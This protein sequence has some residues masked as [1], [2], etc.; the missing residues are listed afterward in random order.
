MIEYLDKAIR[1]VAGQ[2]INVTARLTTD[3]GDLIKE[4][5]GLMFHG[6]ND[7]IKMYGGVYFS[8]TELWQFT[9]PAEDTKGLR[10]RYWY[11]ICK[12]GINLCFKQ[13]LYLL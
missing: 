3:E 5:C 10:G 2:D 7:E 9:I 1:A 6:E 13:P 11:C 4:S 8:D 12:D